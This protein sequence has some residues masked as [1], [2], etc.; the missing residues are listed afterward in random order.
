[1]TPRPRVNNNSRMVRKKTTKK[2][3]AKEREIRRVAQAEA[4]APPPAPKKPRKPYTMSEERRAVW[5]ATRR[6][7]LARLAEIQAGMRDDERGAIAVLGREMGV[8]RQRAWQIINEARG[9]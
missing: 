8:T 4:K 1:M 9:I 7:A 5:V 6:A 3:S 2:R